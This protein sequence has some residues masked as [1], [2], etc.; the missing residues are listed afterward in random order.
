[1]YLAERG[2]EAYQLV[3]EK[4]SKDPYT[5]E[6]ARNFREKERINKLVGLMEKDLLTRNTI[7][8]LSQS[9]LYDEIFLNADLVHYHLIHNHFF[10]ITHLP[11]LTNLKPSVWTLHDPWAVTGHC[12]HFFDCQKWKRGCGDCANLENEFKLR[13]DA[14]AINWEIKRVAYQA[15]NLDVVVSSKWMYDIVR[16]SP[17]MQHFEAHIIPF[18]I[19][20]NVF[21]PLIKEQAKEFFGIPSENKV[22]AFRASAWKLKGLHYL[23]EALAK[24]KDKRNITLL[25]SNQVGLISDLERDFHVVELGW[26]DDV[27]VLT[28]FYSAADIFVMPSEAESF[29]MSAIE[30]MACG[31]PVIAFADTV[32]EHTIGAP[33]AGITVTK[34]SCEELGLAIQ[35]LFS[36]DNR[37][38]VL[39]ENALRIVE[40][41]H[42]LDQYINNIIGLYRHVI[43]KRGHDRRASYLVNQLQRISYA[44]TE[45]HVYPGI[46]GITIQKAEFKSRISNRLR[47]FPELHCWLRKIYHSLRRLRQN[48]CAQKS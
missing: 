20:L 39:A 1:L 31:T 23:T 15:S 6:I 5:F 29:G 21:K 32:L 34:G 43:E 33:E 24:F 30:S 18:G 17:L 8:P 35:K 48:I 26:I 44:E 4:K 22:V 10:N 37:R 2:F 42:G 27:E 36:E 41:R 14:S 7:S 12:V 3:W 28:K 9:L 45:S 46:F 25:T 11:I 47:S 16:E 40:N 19:N 38:H 13:K